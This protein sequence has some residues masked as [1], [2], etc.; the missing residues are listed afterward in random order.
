MK[1]VRVWFDEREHTN[2]KNTII[3][4]PK[5]IIISLERVKKLFAR[6][7]TICCCVFAFSDVTTRL[8]FT[9]ITS[10]RCRCLVE[11]SAVQS[12]SGRRFYFRFRSRGR[13]WRLCDHGLSEL[14]GGR[15]ARVS[16]RRRRDTGPTTGRRKGGPVNR[17]ISV[18]GARRTT[19]CRGHGR[20]GRPAVRR[21][22]EGRTQFH[23]PSNSYR[24][25]IVTATTARGLA[26]VGRMSPVQ[27]SVP[28]S[29]PDG[30]DR[31][32]YRRL[33]TVYGSV[34]PELRD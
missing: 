8:Y 25:R 22:D 6:R 7:L 18:P 11:D 23:S 28:A 2:E 9:S 3:T 29:A 33:W 24:V 19:L 4:L 32:R 26:D 15:R 14:V 21:H 5:Y 10:C 1:D 30:Q 16:R 31:R 34:G 13:R 20:A 17:D 12:T 27:P